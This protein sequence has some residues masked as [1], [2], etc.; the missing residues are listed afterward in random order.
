M[1]APLLT[2]VGMCPN[3]RAG[4]AVRARPKLALTG[5]TGRR[6][7]RLLG[8]EWTH[9]LRRTLRLNVLAAELVG[10]WPVSEARARA[11]L[12]GPTLTGPVLLL[13]MV[14]AEAFDVT[15]RPDDLE[16]TRGRVGLLT[17]ADAVLSIPHPSGRCRWY[18]VPDNREAAR[19]ALREL[20]RGR[21]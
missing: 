5:N 16:P 6:L 10:G 18:N 19:R 14:V 2:I 3:A 4:A 13:G 21:R 12:I 15:W 1:S 17:S 8:W 9:Y 20:T 11:E 7:A